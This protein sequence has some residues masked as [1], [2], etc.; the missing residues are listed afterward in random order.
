MKTFIWR[1]YVVRMLNFEKINFEN[2]ILLEDVGLMSFCYTLKGFMS[3]ND[4][5]FIKLV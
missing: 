4:F 2:F 1:I 3:L 5:D